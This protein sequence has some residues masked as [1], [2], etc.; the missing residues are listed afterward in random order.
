[1]DGLAVDPSGSLAFVAGGRKIYL[2]EV[3]NPSIPARELCEQQRRWKVG[4][5]TASP[6]TNKDAV[7]GFASGSDAIIWRVDGA[8]ANPRLETEMQVHTRRITGISWDPLRPGC[9]ATVALD[10]YV[11]AWDLRTPRR[12]TASFCAWPLRGAQDGARVACSRVTPHLLASSHGGEVRV[13]DLR[14]PLA[15]LSSNPPILASCGGGVAGIIAHEGTGEVVGLDWSQTRPGELMTAAVETG[16]HGIAQGVVKLWETPHGE[17]ATEGK[18]PS[19][20]LKRIIG[21]DHSSIPTW[22]ME[23]ATLKGALCAPNCDGVVTVTCG[24]TTHG[25]KGGI[26]RLWESHEGR[27]AQSDGEH[28]A[29]VSGMTWLRGGELLS[30]SLESGELRRCHLDIHEEGDTEPSE[31]GL[32]KADLGLLMGGEVLPSPPMV[33]RQRSVGLRHDEGMFPGISGGASDSDIQSELDHLVVHASLGLV[34]FGRIQYASSV[35]V[36]KMKNTAR[37]WR[38]TVCM[39]SAAPPQPGQQENEVSVEVRVTFPIQYPEAPPLFEFEEGNEVETDV[40]NAELIHT[41]CDSAS[42]AMLQGEPCMTTCYNSL[43]SSLQQRLEPQKGPRKAYDESKLRRQTSTASDHENKALTLGKDDHNIDFSNK[44]S[45]QIDVDA[46]SMVDLIPA[47]SWLSGAGPVEGM[48]PCP[49]TSQGVF[50]ANGV[51]TI[52]N[53]F[54]TKNKSQ[55]DVDIAVDSGNVQVDSKEE[56]EE[57]EEKEKEALLLAP[58]TYLELRTAVQERYTSPSFGPDFQNAGIFSFSSSS[59]FFSDEIPD[60][61]GMR[62][63]D[64]QVLSSKVCLREYSKICGLDKRMVH[65]FSDCV[66]R[67][68][69]VKSG[70]VTIARIQLEPLSV[71]ITRLCESLAE[72]TANL[73]RGDLCQTWAALSLALPQTINER[74]EGRSLLA[75]VTWALHPF[76]RGFLDRIVRHY[77]K[78]K[79]FQTIA[80][81]MCVVKMSPGGLALSATMATEGLCGMA[82]AF[83]AEILDRWGFVEER[84]ELMRWCG[85]TNAGP[86]GLDGTHRLMMELKEMSLEGD[87]ITLGALSP[88]ASPRSVLGTLQMA[89]ETSKAT[90][91]PVVTCVVC[92]LPAHG[93]VSVICANGHAGHVQCIQ[94]WF[95]QGADLGCP[96]ACGSPCCPQP[97]SSPMPGSRLAKLS[98]W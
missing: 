60:S 53:N 2:L 36:E 6:H 10:G 83:Y 79:D 48:L 34:V 87:S 13:W 72:G 18:T 96:A 61:M 25:K 46:D 75:G 50:G 62:D 89:K 40:D 31:I 86:E 73:G 43:L 28:T 19:L 3:E 54:A 33:N 37:C 9:L 23:G 94:D 32:G 71:R 68:R 97:L 21:S 95:S 14:R 24:P 39:A 41:L 82:Q 55:I 84:L 26:L 8:S 29:E 76:G 16:E 66:K 42:A 22:P 27:C 93:L 63:G 1:M 64:E 49:R 38:V 56:K 5:L 92:R 98:S 85:S 65:L 35:S 67:Q 70:P 57:K 11:H 30:W 15:A 91:K 58:R 81:I 77:H 78:L 74:K 52:F 69:L 4:L 59:L 7:L 51:L 17:R 90:N 80:L 12:P 44:D 88:I 45:T 47:D 20:K